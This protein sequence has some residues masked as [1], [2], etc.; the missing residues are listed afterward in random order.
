VKDLLRRP[1]F[2][3]GVVLVLAGLVG[4]VIAMGGTGDTESS[5]EPLA[6]D[7]R[8]S[9]GSQFLSDLEAAVDQDPEDAEALAALGAAYVQQARITG[10][11]S[12]YTRAE[13]SLERSLSVQ[14]EGNVAALIGQ[15]SLS[16]GRHDFADALDWGERARDLDPG[17][18]DAL[19]VVGDAL[20]ELGRYEEAFDAFQDMIDIRP[21]LGSYARVSYSRELQGD[22]DGAIEAMEA[23]SRAAASPPDAAFTEHYL[24][25]L[26]WNSGR[27]EEAVEHYQRA[28]QRDDSFMPA[29]AALARA[30]FFAGRTEEA[31]ERY[32]GVI[33]RFPLPQYVAELAD[34]YVVTGQREQAGE[35][36]ELVEV[37]RQLYE[38]NGASVDIDLAVF[39]A[40]NG[41]D[42]EDNLAAMEA[43]WDQRENIFVADA[44]AWQLHKLGRHDEAL[45]YADEALR[46]GTRNARFHYHRAEIHA[47]LGDDEAAQR[48]LTEARAINPNFSILHAEE[49]R[50]SLD[51]G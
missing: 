29:Q 15:S 11:P 10:D 22:I 24:G 47:A 13:E 18:A 45:T 51:E 25:E 30:E 38:A 48:D 43:E 33:D 27:G 7:P 3:I 12:F 32:G 49:A 4:T 17:N 23:A 14:P 36:F 44:L 31:A 6:R 5:G 20:L 16:G 37:Q 35:Q 42:P 41:V 40:D 39:Y 19:G 34:L 9:G 50:R 26:Y 1:L 8:T 21:D 2:A 46:L 28:V